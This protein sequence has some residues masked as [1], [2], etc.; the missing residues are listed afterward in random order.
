M[1]THKRGAPTAIFQAVRVSH[2]FPFVTAFFAAL[3][4]AGCAVAP[5]E[6]A[7]GMNPSDP[8]APVAPVAYRS[9]IGSYESLRP[10]TPTAWRQQNERATPQQKPDSGDSQ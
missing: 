10:A 9:A 3:M 1:S 8:G 5:R 2:P 4:L 6:I 7:S